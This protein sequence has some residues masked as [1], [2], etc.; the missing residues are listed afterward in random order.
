M[1]YLPSNVKDWSLLSSDEFKEIILTSRDFP[2]YLHYEVAWSDMSFLNIY[3][4]RVPDKMSIATFLKVKEV[5]TISGYARI[6]PSLP[7]VQN[8]WTGNQIAD[9]LIAAKIVD[10]S[11][12]YDIAKKLDGRTFLEGRVLGV[13]YEKE[14]GKLKDKLLEFAEYI[15]NKAWKQIES[16]REETSALRDFFGKNLKDFSSE[17][18][19]KHDFIR[20]LNLRM[21]QATSYYETW[22]SWFRGLF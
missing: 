1:Q 8:S 10:E 6:F 18:E 17:E 12:R 15:S 9:W 13:L 14:V 5:K 21:P 4:N 19:L 16:S 20:T 7:M 3:Y 2:Q 11:W 22:G